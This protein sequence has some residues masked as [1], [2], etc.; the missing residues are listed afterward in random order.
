MT[1]IVNALL[2]IFCIKYTN[3]SKTKRK[4]IIYNA[5]SLLTE[6]INYNIKI[7]NNEDT[8]SNITKKINLIYKDIKKN[9]IAP[10]TDYLFSGLDK[11]SNL[12][13]TIERIEKMNEIDILPQIE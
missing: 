11:K 2:D 4:Y 7:I 13:K 10:E 9:E 3:S 12:E 8:I 1:K 6:T 5:I